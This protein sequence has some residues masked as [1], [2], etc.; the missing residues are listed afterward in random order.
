MRDVRVLDVVVEPGET[1]F[2]RLGWWHQVD[3]LAISVSLSLTNIDVKN[4]YRFCNP[5]MRRR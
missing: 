3:A 1:L 4:G 2:L 5:T